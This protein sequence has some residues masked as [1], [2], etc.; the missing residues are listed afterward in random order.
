MRRFLLLFVLPLLLLLWLRS[1]FYAVDQA[2]FAYVTRFGEPLAVRDGETEAGLY[3]KLPWPIDS[4]RR[5]DRR[6]QVF[7]LPSVEALTRDPKEKTVDKT[8][9]VDAFVCWRIPDAAALDRFV[10]TCGTA[11]QA[12][13]I[14]GP[15]V[16]GRLAAVITS[17]PLDELISVANAEAIERRTEHIRRQLLG[18][19][20]I[21]GAAAVVAGENLRE[22]A[23]A[24][25]GIEIVDLR[26]RRFNYPEAVRATIAER[27]RSERA[28]KVADYESQGRLKAA[29]IASE[30]DRDARTIEADAR[31]ERQRLEGM[32]D[33]EADQI[34]N[35][36]HAQDPEFYAFLKKLRA[37]QDIL[38]Q[39]RDVL[40]L[41]SRHE[42]FDLLLKPPKMNGTAPANGPASPGVVG[43]PPEAGNGA[44]AGGQ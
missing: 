38:T 10:R 19:D 39:S 23:L 26:L 44:K 2:E 35:A 8:L 29:E 13:R 17:M 37:Y 40:L 20:P 1:A 28:R 43:A 25:Y 15:R 3:V 22:E 31:A 14:L 12:R 16:S 27:I 32:A 21:G 42:L 11:E 41:S 5:I 9:A 18:L 4:V 24:E 6:L 34:R 7:D 30:A 33:V 36:A